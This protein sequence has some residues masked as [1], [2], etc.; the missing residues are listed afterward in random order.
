[1]EI[2]EMIFSWSPVIVVDISGAFLT[3]VIAIYS[4]ILSR[5]WVSK[6]PDDIFRQYISL[7]TISIVFFAVSR[8]FGH[9]AKQILL[10]NNLN[11]IWKLI[12]PFSGAI[13]ST[14]FVVIFAFGI[15]FHRFQRIHLEIEDYRNNLEKMIVTRTQELE[16]ANLTIENVLNSSNPI[17]FTSI[18]NTV[19]QTNSAYCLIWP[20]AKDKGKDLKCYELHSNSFCHTDECSLRQIIAGKNEVSH[21]ISQT[22]DGVTQI[23]NVI[24]KPFRNN[25]GELVGVVE[26][27]HDVS[28][29]K[30]TETALI[31]ERER[32]AVTLRSIA[33]GVV[34]TNLDGSILFIN[35]VAEQLSGWSQD[36]AFGKP[37][38]DVFNIIDE[39][40]G[41]PCDNNVNQVLHS[42]KNIAQENCIMLVSRNGRKYNIENSAAPMVDDH[43]NVIGIV[44]VYR[45]VTEKSKIAEELIKVKKLESIGVLAGGIAHDFNNIL[46][47]ILGNLE[48]AT[49]TLEPDTKLYELLNGAKNASIRAKGLTQQLLTFSKGGNPVKKTSSIEKTIIE[50]ANFVLRGSSVTADVNIPDDLLLV[51][52]DSGQISQVIQNLVINSIHS[53]PNGGVLNISCSNLCGL[54]IPRSVSLSK[55]AYIKII[56]QDQGS[57]ISKENLENIFDPYFSTKKTGSGLGL[58]ISNSIIVKHNGHISVESKIGEGTTFSIYLPASDEQNVD[59]V[60]LAPT[61]AVMGNATILVMDD[62][63]L[64][65]DVAKQML[66]HFGHRDYK[67]KMA[68]KPLTYSISTMNLN[69]QL[70]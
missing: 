40:T 49:F 52:I 7:L 18:D 64:V 9:I 15:Y 59:S 31:A 22:I 4:F 36:E 65:Q 23:F 43:N 48:I 2:A 29:L 51:D 46:T 3:L 39:K 25:N 66:D 1:M 30:R 67:P 41:K 27:F 42:G 17:C 12:S 53:M 11:D 63:K 55:R 6:K 5:Q 62:D 45:D 21:E 54:D 70:I 14:A 56:V 38:Q 57:G 13:N 32:L 10:A 33:D 47:A 35:G 19:I 68:R 16:N 58:A 61:V 20:E 24:A 26:S 34:T 44:L 37:V 60:T 8:S 69:S 28:D 50:S